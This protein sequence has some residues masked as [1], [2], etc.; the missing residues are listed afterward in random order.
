MG[1]YRRISRVIAKNLF[2]FQSG[3]SYPTC[4]AILLIGRRILRQYGH[5]SDDKCGLSTPR[6]MT[7]AD[8]G[9]K[10]SRGMQFILPNLQVWGMMIMLD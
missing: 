4:S 6:A 1:I 8:T 10:K 2:R 9:I 7:G 3:E 5:G